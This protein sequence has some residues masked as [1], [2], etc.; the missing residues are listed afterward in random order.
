[1]LEFKPL[2][3]KDKD[4]F[5]KYLKPYVYETCEYSFTNLFIWRKALDIQYALYNDV[6]IVMKMDFNGNFH[7]MQPIG[8]KKENLKEL[9]DFLIAQKKQLEIKYLFKDAE[10]MFIKD[11]LDTYSDTNFT[12]EEDRDNFDYIYE[13]NALATLSG[14]KLHKKKNHYNY[15]IKNYQYETAPI[16][17]ELIQPC[18]RAAREWCHKNICK[19]Y[20][21]YELKSIEEML[22][23]SSN[24][25]FTG[26]VVY[27]NDKI[28]AFTIGEKVNESMAIIHIEK[29]DTDIR[30]LSNFINKTFVE[31]C[32]KDV[33][34]IN[35]EQ[36]LGLE[37]LRHAKS[38][39][40]P[41]RFA[42]KF[43]VNT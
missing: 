38:S 19:G 5:D 15:F 10:E 2:T 1:M 7:F 3:I 32:Y 35:R 9:T 8:Y 37:G 34:Y 17:S 24:L 42:K 31:T 11:I 25:D 26:M 43:I 6:M 13:S 27:V 14:K 18:I 21:L 33:P 20:L 39:Y 36:D 22:K 12:I 4:M 40:M 28:S 41:V 16:T 30:G 23:N 29:A